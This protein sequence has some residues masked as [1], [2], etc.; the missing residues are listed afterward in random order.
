MIF[1]RKGV[2]KRSFLWHY[3]SLRSLSVLRLT[4]FWSPSCLICS[5]TEKQWIK[6]LL[7]VN[8]N[9]HWSTRQTFTRFP[10]RKHEPW[11]YY[12]FLGLSPSLSPIPRP[13]GDSLAGSCPGFLWRR[14]FA[15]HNTALSSPS[16]SVRW[17]WGEW[18]GFS[19]TCSLLSL[20]SAF[21]NLAC[22]S[23][24][25][26]ALRFQPMPKG[27]D[28]WK[29]QVGPVPWQFQPSLAAG[30]RQVA[31]KPEKAWISATMSFIMNTQ[32]RP[33]RACPPWKWLWTGL[34]F[35]HSVQP[36][37]RHLPSPA[38]HILQA[39]LPAL[40]PADHAGCCPPHT[41]VLSQCIFSYSSK[42]HT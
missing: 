36:H 18:M 3:L 37:D 23:K 14:P 12:F 1:G 16:L 2:N 33:G 21:A 31:T 40:V 7:F 41:N 9:F 42:Q 25:I 38:A 28:H 20:K 27:C 39:L 34:W 30:G 13:A 17:G 24:S 10:C 29:M 5:L 32:M 6:E 26:S 35:L 22:L 19:S 8:R 11:Y 15:G 4:L